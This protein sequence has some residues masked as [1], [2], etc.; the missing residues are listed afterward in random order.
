M[1][2]SVAPEQ[3]SSPAQKPEV[4]P[5]ATA[6]VLTAPRQWHV[7]RAALLPPPPPPQIASP[8]GP[9]GPG[10]EPRSLAVRGPAA[11]MQPTPKPVQD[12][13]KNR[14]ETPRCVGTYVPDEMCMY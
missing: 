6:T 12:E 5:E 7:P 8:L 4:G 9:P 14:T 3:L 10:R 2:F 1:N 11:L 13:R